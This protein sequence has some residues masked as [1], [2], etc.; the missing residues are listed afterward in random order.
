MGTDTDCQEG[1]CGIRMYRA[2]Q[3]PF[4]VGVCIQRMDLCTSL[5]EFVMSKR[6][7]EVRHLRDQELLRLRIKYRKQIHGA[8]SA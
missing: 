3:G 4:M 2:R 7:D 6:R 1:Y 5:G 8:A